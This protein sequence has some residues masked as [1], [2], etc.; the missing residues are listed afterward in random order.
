M[1]KAPSRVPFLYAAV[2]KESKA[3]IQPV[4]VAAMKKG[5]LCLAPFSLPPE[6]GIFI[7]YD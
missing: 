5:R 1:Q 3:C 4:I 6:A 2:N 7:I